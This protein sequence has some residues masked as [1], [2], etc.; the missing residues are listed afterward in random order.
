MVEEE[1]RRGLEIVDGRGREEKRIGDWG[2]WMVEEEKRIEDRGLWME[3]EEW[4]R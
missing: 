3:D 2:S 1:K 4:R